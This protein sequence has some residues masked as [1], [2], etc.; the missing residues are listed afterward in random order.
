MSE[1][2]SFMNRKVI[3]V[4]GIPY[5]WKTLASKSELIKKGAATF[6]VIF[7][8]FIWNQEGRKVK[9]SW[10]QKKIN[11]KKLNCICHAVLWLCLTHFCSVWN[12]SSNMSLSSRN[13]RAV[14]LTFP[15]RHSYFNKL[16]HPNWNKFWWNFMLSGTR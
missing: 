11:F 3:T 9:V 7:L 2:F 8:C 5:I 14:G 15:D 6:Y 16:N 12:T 10:Y 1:Q 4:S 13:P